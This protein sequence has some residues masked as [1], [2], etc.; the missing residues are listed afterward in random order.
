IVV[1]L[2]DWLAT[3]YQSAK[4]TYQAALAANKPVSDLVFFHAPEFA[5]IKFIINLPAFIIVVLITALACIGINESRKS[6][7]FMVGLKLVVLC[8]I[9]VIGF[10]LIFSTG[11]TGNWKPFLPEGMAGVM[12][13]VS[14]VFFAYIGFDALLHTAGEM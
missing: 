13:S 7:N 5:G 10:W 1:H 14:S 8:F 12:Q 2:P 6:A 4:M 3:G 9:A 11:T